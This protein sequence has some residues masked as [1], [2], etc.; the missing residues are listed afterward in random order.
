MSDNKRDIAVLVN[1]VSASVSVNLN[2]PLRTLV[3]AALK[4]TD[5]EHGHPVTDW[6][7]KLEGVTLDLEKKIGDYGFA[8]DVVLH[9]D[10][11]AGGG[12]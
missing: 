9:V 6:E 10:L 1:G 11:R 12:G 2:A 8:A 4:E 3:P 7:V 5:Q